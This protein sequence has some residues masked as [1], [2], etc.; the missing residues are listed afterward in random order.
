MLEMSTV[1]ELLGVRHPVR[2]RR[3]G[4]RRCRGARRPLA[5]RA[6]PAGHRR[7]HPPRGDG[8]R[9]RRRRGR[10]PRSSTP[11][12]FGRLGFDQLM[13][14]T[15]G[16][17]V[18]PDLPGIDLPFVHGVQTL[19]DAQTLLAL[20]DGGLPSDRHRRWRLHRPGD[21]RGVRRAWVHGHGGRASDRSRS[22]SST[23]TSARGWPTRCG[24]TASTSGAA[25]PSRASNPG[26][27]QT[28]E[29]SVEADLVVLGIGVRRGPTLAAE[30]GIEL[31]GRAVPILVDDRQATQ[32]RRCVVGRRLRH[33]PPTSSPAQPV[34]IALGTYANKHGRV[35]GINMAG[36]DARS[37]RVLGTAI[38][39]LCSLEI[40]LTGLRVDRGARGRVRRRRHDRS[41]RRPS[42]G[43][44]P[45]PRR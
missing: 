35:A 42:P 44:C 27:V 12:T 29:G 18:R 21:G 3:A 28:S 38:T 30:A 24:R 2:R 45:T 40:A 1:H 9:P 39:K 41:T 8:D 37:P 14:A 32:R 33:R 10:V 36:G 15:G 4:R 13:I 19:D 31:G 11:A 7:A 16:E 26:A 22:A 43:T 34:H 23:S 17:P 25:S 5:G 6:S 20:A